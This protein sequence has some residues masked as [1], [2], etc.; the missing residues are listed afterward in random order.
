MMSIVVNNSAQ[1]ATRYRV[2][3]LEIDAGVR[4]VRRGD[5]LLELPGL[6]F[7]LLLALVRAAPNVLSHDDLELHV[8]GGRPVTPETMTQ[9]VKL[10]RDALGDSSESPRYSGWLIRF[11]AAAAKPSQRPIH[12]PGGFSN[13][14]ST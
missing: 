12:V 7:D 2:D 11:K 6:S 14:Q 8:W 1:T 13:D 4:E 3:D 9:R 5:E 10:V